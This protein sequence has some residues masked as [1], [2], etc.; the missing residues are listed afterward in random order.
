MKRSIFALAIALAIT[1][2]LTAAVPKSPGSTKAT[3]VTY[4]RRQPEN[5]FESLKILKTRLMKKCKERAASAGHAS[6]QEAVQG[7]L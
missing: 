4:S 1:V 5:Y 7:E 2:P 6:V 3:D